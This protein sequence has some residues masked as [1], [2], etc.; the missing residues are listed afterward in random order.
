MAVFWFVRR[1][2]M[3]EVGLLD[4]DFF[5]YGEDIDWCRRFRDAGW[6]VVFY[7]EAETIHFGGASSGNAP[8]RFY[9]EMQ[10]PIC[11]LERNIM[12]G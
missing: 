9:L 6:E 11:N 4:E 7:P 2:A 1:K 10:E 3:D 5:F 8:V 12:A